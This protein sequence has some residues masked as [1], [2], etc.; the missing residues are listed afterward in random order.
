VGCGLGCGQL[1]P[2]LHARCLRRRKMD[3]LVFRSISGLLARRYVLGGC[4]KFLSFLFRPHLPHRLVAR[5]GPLGMTDRH[6]C[7]GFWSSG[8]APISALGFLCLPSFDHGVC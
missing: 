8:F 1:G 7:S 2:Q 6:G 4:L 3:P 5:C